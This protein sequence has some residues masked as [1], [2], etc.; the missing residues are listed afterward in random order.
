MKSSLLK[1]LLSTSAISLIV[2]FNQSVLADHDDYSDRSYD[3]SYNNSEY[4]MVDVVRAEPFYK[5][6]TVSRPERVCEEVEVY[7]SRRDRYYNRR[8]RHRHDQTAG[9]T[10]AGGIIG[11]VIG[12]QF[13]KGKGRDAATIAGVLIG[14]AIGH[15]QE[16]QKSGSRRHR[17]RD[18]DREYDVQ[19]EQVCRVRTERF[20]EERIAGYDVT[21]RLDGRNY[22]TRTKREPGSQMRIRISIDDYGYSG[23]SSDYRDYDDEYDDYQDYDYDD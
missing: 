3:R 23:S 8:A 19:T 21:Y 6:V 9:G 17:D 22:T 2:L 12:R 4:I 14:S 1:N 18:Y 5:T 20:T 10:I 11:G 16:S 13:G 7:D 15:D